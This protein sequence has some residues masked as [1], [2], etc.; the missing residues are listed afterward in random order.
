MKCKYQNENRSKIF[1]KINM[2]FQRIDIVNSTSSEKIFGEVFGTRDSRWILNL[3]IYA[4]DNTRAF[5]EKILANPELEKIFTAAKKMRNENYVT[6]ELLILMKFINMK[7]FP[8]LEDRMLQFFPNALK[9][10]VGHA[11]AE[12]VCQTEMQTYLSILKFRKESDWFFIRPSL[13]EQQFHCCC[14]P[15][16]SYLI[17]KNAANTEWLESFKD[18]LKIQC[19][20]G[21]RCQLGALNRELINKLPVSGVYKDE[22]KQLITEYTDIINFSLESLLGDAFSKK[23]G[24]KAEG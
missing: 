13:K 2:G 24:K 16:F 23:T 9:L 22:L 19:K 10:L 11:P 12:A 18:I 5:L 15:I 1:E 17:C 6:Y 20:L 7:N 21:Q 4:L 3:N 8:V 14:P